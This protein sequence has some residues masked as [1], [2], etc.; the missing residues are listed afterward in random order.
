VRSDRLADIDPANPQNLRAPAY[1]EPIFRN[2][3]DPLG[4]GVAVGDLF[5]DGL[6]RGRPHR[7]PAAVPNALP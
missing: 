3:S 4:G 2:A 6:S 5:H 7:W 1:R